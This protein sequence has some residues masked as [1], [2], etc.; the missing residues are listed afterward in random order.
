MGG[1]LTRVPKLSSNP[2]QQPQIPPHPIPT[3]Q[4]KSAIGYKN[5]MKPKHLVPTRRRTQHHTKL[6]LQNALQTLLPTQL[7]DTLRTWLLTLTYAC[8]HLQTLAETTLGAYLA[9][10]T[11]TPFFTWRKRLR[12]HFQTPLH[13]KLYA[14]PLV[15]TLLNTLPH[16]QPLLLALDATHLKNRWIALT[17]AVIVH[18]TA[19]PLAWHLRPA[20]QKGRWNPIWRDLLRTLR[21]LIPSERTVIVVCDRGISSPALFR[22]LVGWG[23]H[24]VMRLSHCVPFRLRYG[25]LCQTVGEVAPLTPGTQGLWAGWAFAA[26]LRSVLIGVWATGC[27]EP[28]YLLTDG[29]LSVSE[30]VA[31][32]R[33]RA[34]IE[35]WFR[36][37]KRGGYGWHRLRSGSS[38]RMS[39]VW[40]VYALGVWWSWL[41]RDAGS[42]C[43]VVRGCGLSGVLVGS[44]VGRVLGQEALWQW[45]GVYRE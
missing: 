19:L 36:Q 8:L 44:L 17:V 27:A 24:P 1:R 6:Y 23:W 3:P 26:G 45:L 33:G 16:D 32:Y 20:H 29:H 39:W 15:Q 14:P 21:S 42:A 11:Q 12:T 43:Q 40:W 37:C 2:Q 9:L 31:A 28:W 4:K 22:L 38:V 7:P 10:H 13:P 35:R 41:M 34:R 5:S 25:R 30:A 18:R